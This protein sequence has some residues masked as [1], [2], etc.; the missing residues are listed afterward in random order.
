MVLVAIGMFL[1]RLMKPGRG[2]RRGGGHRRVRVRIIPPPLSSPALMMGNLLIPPIGIVHCYTVMGIGA[3]LLLIPWTVPIE[4]VRAVVI[5]YSI[6]TEG[7][8]LHHLRRGIMVMRV[9]E[10]TIKVGRRFNVG[11]AVGRKGQDTVQSWNGVPTPAH[12]RC[13]CSE[14]PS[15]RGWEMIM[16]PAPPPAGGP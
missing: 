6:V 2:R 11:V 7:R 16:L 8:P 4:F 5:L 1:G 12:L 14:W 13:S 10:G 9:T 15:T 3:R